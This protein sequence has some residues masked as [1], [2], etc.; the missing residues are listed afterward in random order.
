[1]DVPASSFCEVDENTIIDLLGK[2]EQAQQKT[3]SVQVQRKTL[4][5]EEDDFD[6]D[7]L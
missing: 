5:D 2:Y 6:F 4:F 7:N 3:Q 1:M